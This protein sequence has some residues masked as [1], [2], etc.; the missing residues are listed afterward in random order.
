MLEDSPSVPCSGTVPVPVP[1]N[2]CLLKSIRAYMHTV[3]DRDS[4]ANAAGGRKIT[5]IEWMR[6]GLFGGMAGEKYFPTTGPTVPTNI[7]ILNTTMLHIVRYS[8]SSTLVLLHY[9]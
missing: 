5:S 1:T 3:S 2:D 8:F 7:I 6:E 9:T 4:N